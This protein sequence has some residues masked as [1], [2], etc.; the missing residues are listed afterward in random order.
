MQKTKL[1]LFLAC[2]SVFLIAIS[3]SA[4]LI[5]KNIN[6]ANLSNAQINQ[7]RS[8]MTRRN[9][10]MSDLENEA[11][12]NGMS[13]TDFTILKSRLE[14]VAPE[15]TQASMAVEDKV[16]RDTLLPETQIQMDEVKPNSVY[17]SEFFSTAALNFEPNE[18]MVTPDS[19]VLGVGDEMHVL[20][21]GMQ[22]YSTNVKVTKEGKI[23]LPIIGQLHVAG[24]T[25]GAAKVEV[26]KACSKIYSSLNSGQSHLSLTL[27]NMRTIRVTVLGA[28]RPGTYSVSSLAT[29]FNALHAAGGPNQ[30]G[31]YRKIELIRNNKVIQT[32]DIYKFL[33]TGDQSEN[34]SLQE[35]DLIRIPVYD[36]R[37]SIEGKIKRPGVYELLPGEKFNDLLEY[38]GG[39]DEAA[40]RK[41]IKLIRN[42]D[43]GMRVIDMTEE[44]YNAYTPELGDVFKVSQN[45]AKFDNKVSI[46][47][48]VYRPDDYEFVEGMTVADL[49]SK[50]EGFRPDAYT[51]RAV[52]IREKEDLTKVLVDVNVVDGTLN[53][54]KNDELVISSSF[55]FKNQ[56]TV[57]IGGQVKN[58]GSYPYIE[59]MTLYDLILLAGGFTEMASK[60]LEISSVIIKDEKAGDFTQ[61][62]VVKQ[63]EIDTLLV[64]QSKNLAIGP[65]D[66][67]NIRTKPIFEKQ[68]TV[69]IVGPV[70][71]PGDYVVS[72]KKER[73]LDVIERSGGFK[74]DADLNAIRVVRKVEQYD[75]TGELLHRKE[76][77]IP[78]DYNKI[79]K[80]PESEKNFALQAGDRIVVGIKRGTVLVVGHVERNS[81]I[82]YA[83]HRLKY[84][85]SAAG[86]FGNDP[87][88]KRVYIIYPNGQA[89]ETKSFMGI[90]KY[91]K[92]VPG[93]EIV[94]PEK[95]EYKR[96]G[97]RMSA[98]EIIGI[99]SAITGLGSITLAIVRLLQQ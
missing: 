97:P 83:N 61:M 37:V 62:S 3:S 39:F 25:Y 24:L 49:I 12:N 84:Y 22:E 96:K 72:D 46:R 34:V 42:T 4:Q 88:K 81:E 52:L 82:P 99:G 13:A 70:E 8:E 98:S 28:Q 26:K 56:S 21:Y 6:V 27:T 73:V 47:G 79:L 59:N 78:I 77:I 50:A 16:E 64:D 89:K 40:F 92:V 65:H 20:V 57:Y 19:Y 44:K 66:I 63:W 11:R 91:P 68:K 15:Q 71:Y 69:T 30:Y 67:V 5:D 2:I 86:G 93:S 31:T 18:N 95:P 23:N 9:M 48:A 60:H 7:I 29:V 17:G 33:T 38:C 94:V 90:R 36:I 51:T 1:N 35:N 74:Y 80:A 14:A 53:L 85:V 58:S 45:I 32:I 10:S 43:D 75:E 55:D 54:Q 76:I 41:N 87:F